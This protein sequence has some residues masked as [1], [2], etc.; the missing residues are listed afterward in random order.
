MTH[1][2]GIIYFSDLAGATNQLKV[3]Y[4]Y[5]GL[6]GSGLY[7]SVSSNPQ[8]SGSIYGTGNFY[9]KSGSGFFGRNT[10]ININNATGFSSDTSWTMVFTYEFSGSNSNNILF[11]NYSSG[12]G[13]INSGFVLGTANTQQPYL[14]Y[15][16]PGGP[17][18][19]LSENN[20]GN[21]STLLVTKNT[22]SVML[23]YFDY[24]SKQFESEN[25]Y[26][27]DT[28]FLP[29][30]DWKIGGTGNPPSYF[31]GDNFKG[32][33]DTF[34]YYSPAITS[35]QK[36]IIKSGL[37]CN[38]GN[39]I[40]GITSNVSSGITGYITGQTLMFT[41]YTGQKIVTGASSSALCSGGAIQ[42]YTITGISGS[43]YESYISGI[44]QIITGYYTGYSGNYISENTGYRQTFKMDATTYLK[45]VDSNDLS[46]LY[47]CSGIDKINFNKS[48][49]YDRSLN[50]FVL[51]DE[52]NLDNTNFYLNGVGQFGSGYSTSG[53]LYNNL[54]ILSGTYYISGNYLSGSGYTDI[55]SN[56]IDMISGGQRD[57]F[58][59]SLL[60]SG[61]LIT[62]L[63]SGYIFF[64]NG[65]KI[66]NNISSSDIDYITGNVTGSVFSF[67]L[68]SG[69]GYYSGSNNINTSGFSRNT[70][71]LYLNGVR[72][73]INSD[74]IEVGR[75]SLLNSES[76][77]LQ[78]LYNI[79]N[80][81]GLYIENL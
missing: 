20:W 80:N 47:S 21:K 49:I 63:N 3:C 78:G 38:I 23:E 16:T 48:L 44:F 72:Q 42:S 19:V 37:Y 46:E 56:I 5:T 29:A 71:Q 35:Y 41:G 54:V 1:P 70:S 59:S 75:Y 40:S 50:M 13:G 45:D 60:T 36:N 53:N 8:Y 9:P 66:Q 33:M 24:N 14:E 12:A 79:Y 52:Y 18:I 74:Y 73:L 25:F 31:S 6:N 28:Y 7:N 62:G 39:I 10:T 30:S 64:V 67:P 27:D 4:A 22:N 69:W 26:T 76:N 17:K 57:I 11:S 15:Y 77:Y 58:S 81:N 2:T 61:K 68:E 34:L 43:V 65:V 32:Y 55:D 51:P